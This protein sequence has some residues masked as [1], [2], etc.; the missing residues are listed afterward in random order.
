MT[1]LAWAAGLWDGEGCSSLKQDRGQM[2]F[3]AQMNSTDQA[4]ITRFHAAVAGGKVYGPYHYKS[5]PT[6]KVY[7]RWQAYG[8]E[9]RKVL[10]KLV[11][12]LSDPKAEQYRLKGGGQV[13]LS[14]CAS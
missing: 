10:D 5:R 7:W 11:P 12:Y 8:N 13:E 2:Y 1:E 14:E 6:S 4:L 9:A 3:F